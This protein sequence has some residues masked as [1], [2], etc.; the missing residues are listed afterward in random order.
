[1]PRRNLSRNLVQ[2]LRSAALGEVRRL[3][4][5]GGFQYGSLGELVAAGISSLSGRSSPVYALWRS[6]TAWR[7]AAALAPQL[8]EVSD[9][10]F[11]R[12]ADVDFRFKWAPSDVQPE[13]LIGRLSQADVK[14]ALIQPNVPTTND[15]GMLVDAVGITSAKG[16]EGVTQTATVGS[17]IASQTWTLS[18]YVACLDPLGLAQNPANVRVVFRR[19]D[20]SDQTNTTVS[21]TGAG[22]YQRMSVTKT[23]TGTAGTT[24]QVIVGPI[25]AS[26]NSLLIAAA[27][28][29]LA[30]SATAYERTSDSAAGTKN[31]LLGSHFPTRSPWTT[32]G[33]T[34]TITS[35]AGRG[36][37]VRAIVPTPGTYEFGIASIDQAFPDGRVQLLPYDDAGQSAETIESTS[38]GKGGPFKIITGLS[39]AGKT[40]IASCWMRS[41]SAATAPTAVGILLTP[42]DSG[43]VHL[44]DQVSSDYQITQ[45]W[46]R[47]WHAQYVDPSHST[48]DRQEVWF[49]IDDGNSGKTVEMWGFQLE[50]VSGDVSRLPAA[51]EKT[52]GSAG[53]VNILQ[54]SEEADNAYWSKANCNVTANTGYAPIEYYDFQHP[55]RGLAPTRLRVNEWGTAPAADWSTPET[56]VGALDSLSGNAWSIGSYGAEKL[57]TDG[58]LDSWAAGS[59]TGWTRGGTT[60]LITQ[61]TTAPLYW[62]DDE[63]AGTAGG[64]A[65]AVGAADSNPPAW[66]EKTI[67]LTAGWHTLRVRVSGVGPSSQ[68][69]ARISLKRTTDN[70]YL[71]HDCVRYRS[72][73]EVW[74]LTRG[75]IGAE[76][77]PSFSVAVWHFHVPTTTSY[78]LRIG[79]LAAS[80]A[81]TVY[82][83][84]ARLWDQAGAL[85][86][87]PTD[88]TETKGTNSFI[89]QG[90]NVLARGVIDEV[91]DAN[92]P[93]VNVRCLGYLAGTDQQVPNKTLR[94]ECQLGF[95]KNECGYISTTTFTAN[96]SG[97]TTHTC[98]STAL[99]EEN[100]YLIDSAGTSYTKIVSILD[101]THFTTDTGQNYTNGQVLRYADCRKSYSDCSKRQRTFR[102]S[103]ARATM[104]MQA[105]LGQPWTRIIGPSG[106]PGGFPGDYDGPSEINRTTA[107]IVG[108]ITMSGQESLNDKQIFD[109][110]VVPL[111]YGRKAVKLIPIESHVTKL[112]D[113]SEWLSSFYA[114][115]QGEIEAVRKFFTPAGTVRHSPATGAGVYWRAGTAGEDAWWTQADHAGAINTQKIPNQKRDFRTNT[116]TAYS[117]M[118]YAIVQIKKG[119]PLVD[120][121]DPTKVLDMWADVK[122]RK[123]QAYDASGVASGSPAWSRNPA[124][125]LIDLLLDK[126]IG[127]GFPISLIDWASFKAAAD[128]CDV[129]ITSGEAK[130]TVREARNDAAQKVVSVSGFAPEMDCTV[131]DVANKVLHVD[132]VNNGLVFQTS[133]NSSIA[134]IVQGFPKRFTCDLAFTSATAIRGMVDA[135]LSTCRGVLVQ[136]GGKYALL[137]EKS[138][139]DTSATT[140]GISTPTSTSAT[141][142]GFHGV[143]KGTLAYNQRKAG[144]GNWNVL[145]V[146]YESAALLS[147]AGRLA[148]FSDADRGG[149]DFPRQMKL[150]ARGCD[151]ADQAL[152][153]MLPRYAKLCTV[154]GSSLDEPRGFELQGAYPGI[155]M[156]VGDFATLTRTGRPSV[157]K[158]RIH[159]IKITSDLK[160]LVATTP[161][162]TKLRAE[163]FLPQFDPYTDTPNV[164]SENGSALGTGSIT[165]SVS[166]S[167]GGQ[168]K[169]TVALSGYAAGPGT[170]AG[171]HLARFTAIELHASTSTGFTPTTGSAGMG[172]TLIAVNDSTAREFVW[173]VPT[174]LLEV[175]L[176]LKAVGL[177]G[178]GNE[179]AAISSEVPITIYATDRPTSDPTQQ[180]GSQALN[181][182]YGG[183]FEN[184]ADWTSDAAAASYPGTLV[185][186]TTIQAPVSPD[187]I[188]FTG[189]TT[190][191]QAAQTEGAVDAATGNISKITD[192]SDATYYGR[193]VQYDGSPNPD[194]QNVAS[195]K[196]YNFGAG[197]NVTGRPNFRIIK[198][199][200]TGNLGTI[201]LYYSQD[202]TVGTPAWVFIGNYNPSPVDV[203][204]DVPGPEVIAADLSKFGVAVDIVC[205]QQFS[206]PWPKT[207]A[208][209]VLKVS[210]E[211]KAAS[212]YAGSISDNY[213]TIYGDNS[214]YGNLRRAFPAKVPPAGSQ[215]AFSASTLNHVRLQVKKHVA[216][217][218]LDGNAVEVRIYDAD[219]PANEWIIGSIPSSDITASWVDHTIKFSPG[220]QVVGT[221]LQI[222]VRTKNTKAVDVDKLLVA[223]GDTLF[224]WTTSPEN[225][226]AGYFGDFRNGDATGFTKGSWTAGTRKTSPV[227]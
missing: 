118:A 89:V 224:A 25:D 181:M 53:A 81:V 46:C 120:L 86:A 136:D 30:G 139:S 142:T 213:A 161:E 189:I 43:G 155:Q 141:V 179:E 121:N 37:E 105:T 193:A 134:W 208:G 214:S 165:L 72:S 126:I 45:A 4:L 163:G 173:N 124:W 112:S 27:Q 49:Y 73:S 150:D 146:A 83:D 3:I 51:Y 152:R 169:A 149:L 23:F 15:H 8:Q 22:K 218:T 217:D 40:Y 47:V 29:E 164:G 130:T 17:S 182:V 20:A 69:D 147:G 160:V 2:S 174:A 211:Q 96:S 154:V 227:A 131:N 145:E 157:A 54:R 117:R 115:A 114:M 127:P 13:T 90:L 129:T 113:N 144:R 202:A 24:M 98:T 62:H 133:V 21:Y 61:V 159:A 223:R 28:L 200:G 5:I 196:A 6:S 42:Q 74:L 82:V 116:D 56:V 67:S 100:R 59:P 135:I 180:E 111:V 138:Q 97:S 34:V 225:Q 63:V 170:S 66:L 99:L 64:A 166:Q 76:A 226:A 26:G 10:D 106:K 87:S 16:L 38:A 31:V 79:A 176:F 119:S 85:Y 122:G 221:R 209:R 216:G 162:A 215:V 123:V 168:L 78:V 219:A 14:H 128:Y 175:P 75:K 71:E 140:W 35:N 104:E 185:A 77:R 94:P 107:A 201:R 68:S 172:G 156:Q 125:I 206:S 194:T 198:P 177:V 65:F 178:M 187:I 132:V 191:R 190:T 222:E 44:D 205:S 84:Q 9:V 88:R 143:I 95:R 18:F 7:T 19:G 57:G 199:A 212:A 171:D 220:S 210:F 36:P 1:M 207:Y 70:K 11:S 108:G 110:K 60:S 91:T 183:D 58:D 103:G 195:F 41:L 192:A 148:R 109:A 188:P 52:V 33:T 204:V 153:A 101:A 184:A 186:P 32:A 203:A 80:A 137:I 102:Y 151:T 197:S 167:A 39:P 48:A 158:T 93:T 50:Q 12:D 92:G 55:D